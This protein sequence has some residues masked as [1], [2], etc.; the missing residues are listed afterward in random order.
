MPMVAARG[1]VETQKPFEVKPLV[2]SRRSAVVKMMAETEARRRAGRRGARRVWS[3]EIFVPASCP[4]VW[5]VGE[6]RG[7]GQRRV[8]A[9]AEAAEARLGPPKGA[10]QRCNEEE[11]ASRAVLAVLNAE[12]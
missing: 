4:R 1:G 5:T 6:R 3:S 9:A 2:P 7:G 8:A 10:A 12:N 11:A